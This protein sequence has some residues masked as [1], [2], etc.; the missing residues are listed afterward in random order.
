MHIRLAPCIQWLIVIGSCY[1]LNLQL[2][3]LVRFKELR[4]AYQRY[5]ITEDC[6]L[7]TSFET[8]KHLILVHLIYFPS[9]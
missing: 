1:A 9:I 8:V 6:M 7:H 3:E 4:S 5:V 2:I